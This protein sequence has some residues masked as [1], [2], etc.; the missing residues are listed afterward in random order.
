VDRHHLVDFRLVDLLF[1][2]ARIRESIIMDWAKSAAVLS[3]P[4]VSEQDVYEALLPIRKELS[5]RILDFSIVDATVRAGLVP[6]VL[7]R[8]QSGT[9]RIQ[10]ECGWIL[11]NIASGNAAHVRALLDC[12]AAPV[13][14]QLCSDSDPEVVH[15]CLWAISNIIGDGVPARDLLIS[16]GAVPLV[17]RLFTSPM[18]D[19]IQHTL[20]RT[21]SNLCR[22]SPPSSWS[23]V[24]ALVSPLTSSVMCPQPPVDAFWALSFLCEGGGVQLQVRHQQWS[25]RFS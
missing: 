2:C 10:V 6:I 19:K 14:L 21:A 16:L 18:F 23:D 4:N 17:C 1:G 20:L 13:L 7:S 11:T 8:L 22:G 15:H 12:N 9:A 24:Q 3:A 25:F 5:T